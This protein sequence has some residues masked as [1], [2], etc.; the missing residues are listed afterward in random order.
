M[1]NLLQQ[2]INNGENPTQVL[3][4]LIEAKQVS[5]SDLEQMKNKLPMI[6]RFLGTNI[7]Q[8]D[9]ANLENMF[10]NNGFRF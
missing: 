1:A 9:I 5:K 10:D 6:N 4:Q 3:S 2:C 7:S 8:N